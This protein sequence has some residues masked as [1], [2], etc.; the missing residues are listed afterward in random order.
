LSYK[1]FF[2][3]GTVFVWIETIK[4]LNRSTIWPSSYRYSTIILPLFDHP[5]AYSAFIQEG[6]LHR[7][8]A[9]AKVATN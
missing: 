6:R 8:P 4:N 5:T 1:Q 7:E 3:E 2:E 9:I